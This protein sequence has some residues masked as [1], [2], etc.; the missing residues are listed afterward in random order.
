MA[1]ETV[2]PRLQMRSS[3]SLLGQLNMAAVRLTGRGSEGSDV[4][5]WTRVH[6]VGLT[7][8]PVTEMNV[9]VRLL[10]N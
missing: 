5:G 9:W 1:F 3:L 4:I 6:K 8:C 10:Q 2:A 7:E